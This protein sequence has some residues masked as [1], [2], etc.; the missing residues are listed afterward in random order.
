MI[1]T[2][3][4]FEEPVPLPDDSRVIG[5]VPDATLAWVIA[6]AGPCGDLGCEEQHLRLYMVPMIGWLQVD[7]D[8]GLGKHERELRPAV[9]LS[10]GRVVDYLR[11]APEMRF[12]ALLRN[13]DDAVPIAKQVFRDRFGAEL[14]TETGTALPN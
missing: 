13:T 1:D 9:M 5:F 12:V 4:M 10:G 2:D 8:R 6:Y 14:V 7:V 11:V 3:T